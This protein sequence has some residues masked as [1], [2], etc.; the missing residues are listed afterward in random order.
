M[1]TIIQ[2]NASDPANYRPTALTSCLWK[3]L[4]CMVNDR[5]VWFL[6]NKRAMMALYRSTG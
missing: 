2:W 4:E 6:E 1:D 3:T 5:L